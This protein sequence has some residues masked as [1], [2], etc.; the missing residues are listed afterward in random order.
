VLPMT[1]TSGVL[2]RRPMLAAGHVN[3]SV[4]KRV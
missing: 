3:D 4:E 1:A 2:S